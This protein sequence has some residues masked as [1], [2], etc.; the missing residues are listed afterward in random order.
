MNDV[1]KTLMALDP[2][3][4]MRWRVRYASY[5]P[6]I[7]PPLVRVGN[8]CLLYTLDLDGTLNVINTADGALLNQMHL[9]AGGD[10]SGN[11]RARLLNVDSE[12][13]VQ[14]VSGFLTFVTFDGWKLGGDAV[15]ACRN[16]T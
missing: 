13:R 9:Y 10:E 8:G 7:L 14:M 2:T 15:A 16:Q 6:P 1:D 5:P 3:G 4:Q 11:P 12:E